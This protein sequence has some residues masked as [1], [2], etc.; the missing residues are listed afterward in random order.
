MIN[1]VFNPN[2]GVTVTDIHQENG[3]TI[4]EASENIHKE[5]KS[6]YVNKIMNEIDF[7]QGLNNERFVEMFSNVFTEERLKEILG[8]DDVEF[9]CFNGLMYFKLGDKAFRL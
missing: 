6:K 4:I 5:E 9:L 8:S 1:G 3:K 7:S 2:G